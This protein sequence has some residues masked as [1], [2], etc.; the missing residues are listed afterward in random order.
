V[1]DTPRFRRGARAYTQDGRSYIVDECDGGLVFCGS[2]NGAE[3]EFPENQLFTEA[4]WAVRGDGRRDIALTRLK[5]NRAYTTA[6]KVDRAAAEQLLAKVERLRS[7]LLDFTAYTVAARILADQKDNEFI[8]GLSIIAARKIFDAAPPDA[9]ATLL[10]GVLDARPDTL[11]AAT[12]L[13]DNL[14][15]A[16]LEKGLAAH[17]EAFE[18]FSDRP[19]R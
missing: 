2:S 4:E 5:Q 6:A 18:E 12:A 19:R 13:G 9:R 15:R 14:M 7:G 8:A 16:M 10:A 1:T 17:A 11:V 3:T